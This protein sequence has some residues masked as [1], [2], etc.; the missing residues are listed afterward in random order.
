MATLHAW[1]TWYRCSLIT[2]S[3]SVI[4][5][6][7]QILKIFLIFLFLKHFASSLIDTYVVH[8]GWFTAQYFI[9]DIFSDMQL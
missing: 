5:L 4:N 7:L 2:G 3:E 1:L 6:Y 8:N 9:L